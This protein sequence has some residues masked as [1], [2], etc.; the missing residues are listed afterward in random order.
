NRKPVNLDKDNFQQVLA[1]HD[2]AVKLKVPNPLAEEKGAELDVELKFKKLSDFAPDAVAAQIAEVKDLLT[3][4]A[5]L[6][7]LKGP[8]GNVPAFRKKVEALVK[9]AAKRAEVMKALGIGEE[10]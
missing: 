6:T 9:D 5:Q 8:M 1:E 10:S 7:A 4:R 2:V 3:L